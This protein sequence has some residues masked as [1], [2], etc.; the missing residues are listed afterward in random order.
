MYGK[1]KLGDDFLLTL[2]IVRD[3]KVQISYTIKA[4]E[5]SMAKLLA[6]IISKEF[7]IE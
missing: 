3:E 5:E 7:T 2:V 4:K 1:S 6:N